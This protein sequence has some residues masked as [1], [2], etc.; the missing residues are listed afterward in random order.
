MG[1]DL[2]EYAIAIEDEFQVRIPDEEAARIITLG[3][4]HTWVCT[5]FGLGAN[6]PHATWEKIVALAVVQFSV[7]ASELTRETR[8]LDLAPDG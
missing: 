3:D 4:V 5:H 1:L 6:D 2:V 8:L 7:D